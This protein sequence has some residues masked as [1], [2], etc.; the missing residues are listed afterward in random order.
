MTDAERLRDLAR[1]GQD[2][3]APAFLF[4][5]ADEL[6]AEVY[7][8]DTQEVIDKRAAVRERRQLAGQLLCAMWANPSLMPDNDWSDYGWMLAMRTRAYEE[9]DAFLAEQ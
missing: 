1:G 5:I 9:A 4:R 2:L 8:E 7:L 3:E 6:D